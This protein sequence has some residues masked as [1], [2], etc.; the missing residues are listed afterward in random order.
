MR[1]LCAALLLS[2]A[3]AHVCQ[4]YTSIATKE[5]QQLDPSAYVKGFWYEV[6]SANVFLTKGCECTRYNM[7]RTSDTEFSDIFTCHKGS[8]TGDVTTLNNHGSFPADMPGKM[9]ESLGP[10]SPPYWVL[11]VYDSGDGGYDAA[12]VYA[13]VGAL[14]FTSEYIYFFSRRP[15]LA[16]E[17][18][19]DMRSHLEL[20]N[21][22]QGAILQVPMANC[23]W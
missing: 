8:P 22:S 12:L 2:S 10:V 9:V 15:S 20:H 6:F 11:K 5:A 4:D 21:I 17:I 18:E 19:A 3:L 14:G 23:T 1:V 13:C 16:A 7:T